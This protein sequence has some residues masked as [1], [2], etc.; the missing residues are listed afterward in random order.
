MH[1]GVNCKSPTHQILKITQLYILQPEQLCVRLK[2]T[3]SK[4]CLLGCNSS[5]STE[6]RCRNLLRPMTISFKTLADKVKLPGDT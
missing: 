6:T 5:F 1:K 3:A 4:F 2:N